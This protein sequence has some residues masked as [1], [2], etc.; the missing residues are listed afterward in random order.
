MSNRL[1]PIL[2]AAA[3]LASPFAMANQ[4]GFKSTGN[5]AGSEF[6]GSQGAT[7]RDEVKRELSDTPRA[8]F[9]SSREER[10]LA[11]RTQEA[12]RSTGWRY[13]GGEVGW[14]FDGR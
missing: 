14:V 8:A 1:T 5:E 10:V 6:V 11:Q 7:S 4:D 13:V 12:T 2:V 9:A 3:A